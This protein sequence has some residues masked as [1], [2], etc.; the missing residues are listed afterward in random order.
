MIFWKK[1][2]VSFCL[3]FYLILFLI[4]FLSWS[5]SCFSEDLITTAKAKDLY[6]LV[7][8]PGHGG[9]DS[10]V[11][12]ADSLLEK[13]LTLSIA[14]KLVKL[15]SAG[16]DIKALLT[17]KGDYDLPLEDRTAIAN[18]YKADLF[19][20]I[21]LSGYLYPDV[22][23]LQI[24]TCSKGAS[25]YFSIGSKNWQS[26]QSGHLLES[27]VFAVSIEKSAQASGVFKSVKFLEAPVFVLEGACMA[28]VEIEAGFVSTKENIKKLSGSEYQWKIAEI[29]SQGIL[30]YIKEE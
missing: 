22:D 3:F 29:L 11:I 23:E 18:H 12:F 27:S 9:M 19:L 20:S 2:P 6:C 25:E 30:N 15:I 21:H 5:P 17:R 7:I 28:A 14:R 24:F 8:D 4:L 16:G 26:V 1:R 13:N 10:G